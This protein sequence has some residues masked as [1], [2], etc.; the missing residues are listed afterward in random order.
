MKLNQIATGQ[1]LAGV[2]VNQI[3]T[4]VAAVPHGDAAVQLIYRT[5]NGTIKERLLGAATSKKF[6]RQRR[7]DLSHLMGTEPTFS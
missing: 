7:S 4:V 3:V 2:E 6:K 1:A 5:P